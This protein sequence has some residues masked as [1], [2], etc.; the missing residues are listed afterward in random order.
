MRRA[1]PAGSPR[2]SCSRCGCRVRGIARGSAD[3]EIEQR[4]VARVGIA[5]RASCA[6]A[7]VR[8]ASVSKMM[9]A[10]PPRAR[11][12]FTTGSAHPCGRPRNRRR[13]R[14]GVG[15]SHHPGS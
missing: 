13:S 6:R 4:L 5:A 10:G 9:H 7:R 11:S 14:R 3:D 12:V 2:R 8:S 1:A 15:R